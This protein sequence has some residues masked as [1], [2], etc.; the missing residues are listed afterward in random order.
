MSGKSQHGAG[1]EPAH[2]RRQ[3]QFYEET[4]E[5]GIFDAEHFFDGFKADPE[6]ALATVKAAADPVPIGSSCATPT[7]VRWLPG[8]L[9][10]SK[11]FWR[12]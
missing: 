5:R 11:G 2:D 4:R 9:A 7:V 10:S 8:S 3:R 1:R 6:Y 12:Q